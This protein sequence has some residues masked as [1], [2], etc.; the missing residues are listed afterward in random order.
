MA[1]I[2]TAGSQ[3]AGRQRPEETTPKTQQ[4]WTKGEGYIL[5]TRDS[6]EKSDEVVAKI[7]GVP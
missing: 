6:K 7:Y 1:I 5:E 4:S 3:K 2:E